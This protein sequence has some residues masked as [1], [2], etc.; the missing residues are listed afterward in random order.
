MPHPSVATSAGLPA[1][2][3]APV[4]GG[5]EPVG[6]PLRPKF[7][8]DEIGFHSEL[9]RRVDAYFAAGRSDRDC[10]QMYLKTATIVGWLVGAYLLLVFAA[11]TWWQAVPLALAIAGAMAAVGFNIQHD[12]GHHAYSRREW[13]N[14]LA[15][16]SLDL[17]GAS[18][19]LWRWKHVVMHHTYPN[20]D[21]QDTDIEA[22]TIARLSP[23]Q[24]RRWFHRWQHLYLWPLYAITAP[25]W[26]LYGDFKEVVTGQMGPHR[27]PRPR[28]WDLLVFLGGKAISITWL[29]IIPMFFHEW[30]VVLLYYL[31]VTGA[32]GIF[33][34][35]VFQLA[36]CVE[37]AEY[38]LPSGASM[39]MADAW[40]VHQIQTTVDFARGS[41]LASWL[42]GGLNF[43]VEHHLFPKVCHVH[44]PALSRIV[45][46]ACR[47]YGVRY[48]SHSSML[49]G[50]R[51]HYRWL[52]RLGQPTPD[53]KGLGA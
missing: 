38:P 42:L 3:A 49:A 43:Q 16:M 53:V 35:V 30:W 24:A 5:G 36:H 37:E 12:G 50:I 48:V 34:T 44:Y 10:W 25:R 51:S 47:E 11:Q 14:R 17:I 46:G 23:H 18:S 19:Y 26:H 1:M 15:A 52:W 40:A 8:R 29:L 27:I 32:V 2:P 28:G 45:E 31:L 6:H 39:R 9:R 22:G 33:L 7:P 20:V 4:H 41:W 13:V 21:G